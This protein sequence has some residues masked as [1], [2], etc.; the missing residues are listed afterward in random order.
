MALFNGVLNPNE[1]QTALFN[2]IIS[3]RV[4]AKNIAGTY[5]SLVEKAR[6]E[7]GLYGDTILQIDTDCLETHDW[8]G[9]A[10]AENLLAIDRPP[11]PKTQRFV[12]NRF[13]QVRVSTD[14][15]LS[16]RG[17]STEGVFM[18]YNGVVLA[19]MTD[20][21]RVYESRL[22]N[23]FIGT[24]ETS[25]GKQIHLID[26]AGARE[27]AS[28]EEE[29]NRL[30][31]EEIAR[32]LAELL[33]RMKDA[34]RDYND[35]GFMRSFSEDEIK[36]IWNSAKV[37]KLKYVD[38]P[39]IFHKE[40]MIQKFEEEILPAE[41]FGRAI[42][43][44]DIGEG[45]V[46]GADGTYDNT[47]GTIFAT[48]EFVYDDKHYFPN[49]ELANGVEI[50]SG[51]GQIPVSSVALM[52]EDVICKIVVKLPPLMSSFEAGSNF[53]NGRALVTNHYLTWGFNTLD[54]YY[55]KP[56]ITVKEK[57]AA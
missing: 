30:E 31:A 25:V 36:V 49:D 20:T 56:F 18:E 1:V 51:D 26:V 22:Y 6:E 43:A 24:H 12:L 7:G 46:I 15:Y 52:T 13:K 41:Y 48:E 23:T 33:V 38:L 57:P 11:A 37:A 35:Y 50:G 54:H 53:W 47:K 55:G 28:T 14:D 2:M 16:K 21:K 10:E 17:F 42:A 40:G 19:W 8:M 9:D 44:G 4:V 3:Q 39:T 32:S 45:K 34:R 29:A 5:S 27:N